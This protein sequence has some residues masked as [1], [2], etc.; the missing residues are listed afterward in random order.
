MWVHILIIRNKDNF[1]NRD[2]GRLGG[3]LSSFLPY[4]TAD[5]NDEWRTYFLDF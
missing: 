3:V 1:V 2:G 5:T 4:F